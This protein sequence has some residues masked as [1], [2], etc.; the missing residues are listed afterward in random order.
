M[1]QGQGANEAK[2]I[3]HFLEIL[4]CSELRAQGQGQWIR[5]Q[6]SVCIVLERNIS[7]MSCALE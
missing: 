2:T 7:W 4:R 3:I 1:E 5:N 6:R